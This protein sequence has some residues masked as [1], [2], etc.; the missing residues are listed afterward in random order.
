MNSEKE[1]KSQ[2]IL[3]TGATGYIGG[4]L[5]PRLLSKGY[6][7]RCLVRDKDRLKG[8]SWFKDIEVFTGNVLDEKSLKGALNGIDSA[9]YLIH[10]LASE[11]DFAEKDIEAAKNF[12]RAAELNNL[13]SII[14]LGGLA[15]QDT[16]LSKH[17]RSRQDTGDALRE[18]ATP[19]T[20]FRCAVVVGSGSISFELIRY[21]S[22]RLPMMVCPKWV[23]TKTQPIG[24]KDALHYLISALEKPE[25]KGR[26]FEIGSSAIM[27]YGDMMKIYAK[28]R[29]LKRLM[30]PVPVLTPKLSSH[31]LNFVTPIQASIAKPLVLSMKNENIIRDFS[32][33][34]VFPEI[35]P[36]TYE[37]AVRKALDRIRDNE[38]ETV[39]SDALSS[40]V[41]DE[42]P[43]TMVSKE[44][45]IFEHR[46]K[47]IDASAESIY[48][49]FSGIGGTRGWY[50]WT[51]SWQVR[52]LLDKLIGG[53]GLRRH[54]K[55]PNK[56]NVG[57]AL[58]FWRVEEVEENKLIRL[59]AEMKVPG[60]AWLQFKIEPMKN[61]KHMLLQTAFFEPKGV[62]GLVYWYMLYPAHKIIFSGLINRIAD[63]SEGKRPWSL[64]GLKEF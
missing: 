8:R 58:D 5:V 3:V 27:S 51:W 64:Q 31:W 17:L 2:T 16:N 32:A 44:G 63:Y 28:I 24:I 62:F 7:V 4:R 50:Y 34:E 53:V 29:G 36:D 57:E 38:I 45:L 20:E 13:K 9:Y 55:H 56:I 41:R 43:V 10:S 19:V 37:V 61:G 30:I 23:Y 46:Q 48:K 33:R 39:W 52:G 12:G 21:L 18:F 25:S 14:Y 49:V 40:S 60:K 6:K 11:G 54:R 15:Q 1:L 26:I 59:R 47:I 22:E 42:T 35:T